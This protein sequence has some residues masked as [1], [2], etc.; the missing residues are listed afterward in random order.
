MKLKT[1]QFFMYSTAILLL[2]VALAKFISSFGTARIL[3]T[4]DPI[5]AIP[6]R[7][8]FWIV[9]GIEIVVATVCLFSKR[10]LLKA[11][12]VAWLA[13]SFLIYRFCLLCVGYQKPC[14]CLG[15]LT[16]ALHLS[17]QI[18]NLA[19]KIILGYLLLGNY[20]TLF[21]LWKQSRES[22]VGSI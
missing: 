21:W 2:I 14:S 8:V 10:L 15:N 22:R 3:Q 16:D 19:M 20:A 4:P 1:I 18:T 12:L 7:Y 6:F 5:L 9:G 13:T 11:G 17:P